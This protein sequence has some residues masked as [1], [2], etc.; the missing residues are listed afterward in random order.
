MISIAAILALAVV[1]PRVPGHSIPSPV[2]GS[3]QVDSRHSYAQIITDGTTD[4]GKKKIDVT[5][6][7]ARLNGQMQLDEND[8]AKSRVD[9]RIYPA[10]S[11]APPI[12]EDGKISTQW[13]ANLA[14]HTLVCF[15]S[16]KIVRMPDGKVQAS[17]DLTLTRVDRNVDATPSEAY[18]GPVYGP[19]MVHRVSHEATFIFDLSEPAGKVQKAG[20][21]HASTATKVFRED[22]PQLARA[23]VSAYWPPLIE[24]HNCEAPAGT[25]EAYSG[26]K[27]TGTFLMSPGLPPSPYARPGEDYP[28]PQG[29]NAV[30]GERVAFQIQMDLRPPAS[31]E[32]S[33]SGN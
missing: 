14:N 21:L 5:L 15:H 24:D 18:A 31:R 13:L 27:C 19:P 1:A 7:F 32:Q 17:G 26:Q 33:G 11:M 9:F 20:L 23:V 22:F 10:D 6:G 8:P 12:E 29:F 16:K 2:S 25:G 3:W 4:F 30:I 28:G